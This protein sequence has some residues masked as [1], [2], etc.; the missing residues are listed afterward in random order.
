L[1]YKKRGPA[2]YE[3]KIASE[4]KKKPQHAKNG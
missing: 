1:F 3:L 4:A 2:A